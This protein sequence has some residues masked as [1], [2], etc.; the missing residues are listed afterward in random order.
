MKLF[1]YFFEFSIISTNNSP[2]PNY[3]LFFYG[4]YI[5]A[6]L[7]KYLTTWVPTKRKRDKPIIRMQIFYVLAKRTRVS[8]CYIINEIF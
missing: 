5:Q 2:L 3:K 6:A 8:L 4:C 7:V 1:F